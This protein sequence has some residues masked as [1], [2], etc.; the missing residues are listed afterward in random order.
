M[1]GLGDFWVFLIFVIT[2]L[3]VVLCV[4]YGIIYW[5]KNS[6]SMNSKLENKELLEKD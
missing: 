2:F 6:E 5:N 4:V 3:S 1:L